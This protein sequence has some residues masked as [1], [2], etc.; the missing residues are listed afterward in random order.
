M[1]FSDAYLQE[2]RET[3]INSHNLKQM[4]LSLARKC[5]Q[6]EKE[7]K[8][9]NNTKSDKTRSDTVVSES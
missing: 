7:L 4:I 5:E 9:G 1:I 8:D 6:L 2:L 3:G